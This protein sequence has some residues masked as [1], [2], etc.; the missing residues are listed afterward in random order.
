MKNIVLL[1]FAA[2]LTFSC[3]TNPGLKTRRIQSIEDL[4]I[5]KIENAISEEEIALALEYISTLDRIGTAV[6]KEKVESLLKDALVLINKLFI[7]AINKKSFLKASSFFITAIESGLKLE[8]NWTYNNLILNSVLKEDRNISSTR[9]SY[10]IRNYLNLDILEDDDIKKL[11]PI[12]A[13]GGDKSLLKNILLQAENRSL[14]LKNDY[15]KN[16]GGISNTDLLKGTVTIWVNRGMKI[17]GGI[18]FPDSVIG[19][20]FFIDANG[21]LLTNYHVIESEV[22]PEFEGFSRLYVRL[23]DDQKTR[24]PAKVI[25]WDKVF[26]IALLKVELTPEIT[27]SF[28]QNREYLPGTPIIAIGSPGGLEN[29]ITSGIISASGR[30]FLQMGSVI[31][32][33]VPINHGNSGGPLIDNNGELVGVVFAGIEQFEGINFALPGEYISKLIPSLYK[34]GSLYHPFLGLAVE[35]GANGL[36]IIYR[37]PGSGGSRTGLENGDILTEIM[38]S[39]VKKTDDVNKLLLGMEPGSAVNIKW[40]RSG[41][42]MNGL[43]S[44]DSR[45]AFPLLEAS[46]I[47]LKEN[48]IPPVFGMTVNSISQGLFGS[49]YIVTEVFPGSIADITGLSV[50][51]PFTIKK[52]ELIDDQKIIIMQ[53]KIKKRKAGFL[54]SGVQLGAYL[55]SSNFI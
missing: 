55:G 12:I 31:Q 14:T 28:S 54:E 17:E 10:I 35:E 21:Y 16:S 2:I 53:I 30:K 43:I 44:L 46:K 23:W 52:W 13:D 50:N 36:R 39:E 48:I 27:F 38:G 20:G 7:Q 26:D 24:I 11:L 25:G 51:D 47:D 41:L 1:C 9:K 34:G 40:L 42:E 49:E 22:D 32:V 33:D 8:G 19:S 5:E 29:T 4:S 37:L 45:P 18:G 6:D 15:T 3:T